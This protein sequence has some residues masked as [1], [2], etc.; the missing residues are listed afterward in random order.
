VPQLTH[1]IWEQTAGPSTAGPSNRPRF[2]PLEEFERW[3]EMIQ[4]NQSL[5]DQRTSSLPVVFNELRAEVLKSRRLCRDLFLHFADMEAEHFLQLGSLIDRVSALEHKLNGRVFPAPR[6]NR[7]KAREMYDSYGHWW[8]GTGGAGRAPY[9]GNNYGFEDEEHEPVNPA[10]TPRALAQTIAEELMHL[11]VEART[12]P[13]QQGPILLDSDAE[14]ES[15]DEII[16][17]LKMA[18]A[19]AQTVA[20]GAPGDSAMHDE[21]PP[22]HRGPLSDKTPAPAPDGPALALH[23]ISMEAPVEAPVGADTN[24]MNL[25]PP[26]VTLPAATNMGIPPPN[27]NLI[28][29]TPVNSQDTEQ[30]A[31]TLYSAPV[32]GSMQ[33]VAAADGTPVNVASERS[34]T[35]E[36]VHGL[37]SPMTTQPPVPEQDGVPAHTSSP[38][39]AQSTTH[40]SPQSSPLSSLPPAA[41]SRPSPITGSVLPPTSSLLFAPAHLTPAPASNPGEHLHVP[42]RSRTPR[43]DPA[44]ILRR[45]P[46]FTTNND[47]SDMDI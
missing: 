33:E 35:P 28:P 45:S 26:D 44:A 23:D 16:A 40:Q 14:E 41:E 11:K 31:T 7:P 27:V 34:P 36:S 13:P 20:P 46:R 29:P 1:P 38:A 25:D 3:Q 2:V 24:A 12:P 17:R 18:L 15:K 10:L 39:P 9:Y 32:P 22:E 30:V 47:G 4:T 19:C 6:L 37:S 43:G 5:L 8:L 42:R 21:G